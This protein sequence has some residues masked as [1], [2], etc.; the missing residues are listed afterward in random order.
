MDATKV[1]TVWDVDNFPD[2]SFRQLWRF[3]QVHTET[4]PLVLGL[5]QQ[6][7]CGNARFFGFA[8]WT[9]RTGFYF[10]FVPRLAGAFPEHMQEIW[11]KVSLSSLFKLL[12]DI[13][14]WCFA[15]RLPQSD[16]QGHEGSHSHMEENLPHVPQFIQIHVGQTDECKRQEGLT[17]S[18]D[19]V[20]CK[21]VALKE[22]WQ[23]RIWKL[24]TSLGAYFHLSVCHQTTT[25]FSK[26]EIF[27]D[28]FVHP[29]LYYFV[30]LHLT[31]GAAQKELMNML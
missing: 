9:R 31:S 27:S 3:L 17:V 11:Q 21:Q 12:S 30:M 15:Q 4:Y 1:N 13:I 8:S 5:C 6:D 16:L 28:D 29:S 10:H 22:E 24:R 25:V 18:P 19:R 2:Q 26:Y 23:R 14:V 20:V 7:Y